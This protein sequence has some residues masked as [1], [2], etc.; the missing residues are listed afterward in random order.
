MDQSQQTPGPPPLPVF[1][2]EAEE[3]EFW[4]SHDPSAYFTAPADVVVRLKAQRK[5]M[6]SVRL[7]Q[8]LHDELKAAAARHGLPYQRLMRELLRQALAN[9]ARSEEHHAAGT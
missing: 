3:R 4:D 9:L 2:S 8:A 1:A 7:D 6:V 5:K